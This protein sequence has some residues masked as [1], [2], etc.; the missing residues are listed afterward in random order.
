MPMKYISVI[1]CLFFF[2]TCT[3][4]ATTKEQAPILET[5]TTSEEFLR[6]WNELINKRDWE[7]LAQLYAEEVYLYGKKKSKQVVIAKKKEYFEKHKTFQQKVEN[8]GGQQIFYKTEDLWFDK[9]YLTSSNV[10]KTADSQISVAKNEQGYWEITEETDRVTAQKSKGITNCR[11]FWYALFKSNKRI[12][13]YKSFD[14]ILTVE[15]RDDEIYCDVREEGETFNP[16][17]DRFT[18]SMKEEKLYHS[19]FEP[20]FKDGKVV[21]YDKALYRRL[22]EFCK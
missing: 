18:F 3:E 21:E 16:I 15:F 8:I 22:G 19:G 6:I 4:T 14:Y 7:N 20:D 9:N 5:A 2:T 13:E 11:N 17:M 1:I 12:Q 10:E